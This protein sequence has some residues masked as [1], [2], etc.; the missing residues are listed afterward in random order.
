MLKELDNDRIGLVTST[1]RAEFKRM[2]M[3]IPASHRPSRE[4]FLLILALA[5]VGGATVPLWQII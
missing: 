2:V 3:S 1:D 4:W 5:V